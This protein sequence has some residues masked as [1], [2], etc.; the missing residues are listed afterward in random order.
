M[1]EYA[2]IFLCDFNV[3]LCTLQ[4][5]RDVELETNCNFFL[6][7]FL[8]SFG[9]GGYL[10]IHFLAEVKIHLKEELHNRFNLISEERVKIFKHNSENLMKIG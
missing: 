2:G 8:L 7:F 10:Y 5:F 4:N 3:S 6:L 1:C 9:G